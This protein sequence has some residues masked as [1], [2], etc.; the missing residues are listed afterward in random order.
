LGRGTVR[1]VAPAPV[2]LPP[3]Q[4]TVGQLVAETVRL[5]GRHFWR[6]LALGVL[7]ASAGVGISA[8]H[9]PLQYLL[10]LTL[11]PAV[12]TLSYAGASAL[13]AG[14]RPSPRTLLTALVAGVLVLLP[15][16]FFA[17]A[18]ILPA[19][20]WLALVGLAVPVAVIERRGLSASLSRAIKLARA[21]YVHALGS[22][23]TLTIVGVVTS[24]ALFFLLRGNKEALSVAAF[25]AILVISPV[26]F[27]G[28]ALLYFDQAARVVGSAPRSRRR[29]NADVSHA[30][31]PDRPGSADAEVEPRPAAGGQP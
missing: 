17:Y 6:S 14:I 3:D 28:A 16:P 13:A 8:V 9:R 24:W 11:E 10:A 15:A 5:Y 4:R 22:L 1:P 25:L 12:L 26:L 30:L 21:D 31:E 2:P 19:I 18:F 20:A 7:P 23:A 27:L 29:R